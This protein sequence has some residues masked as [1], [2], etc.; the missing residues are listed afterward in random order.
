MNLNE[1][2]PSNYL[3]KNDLVNSR[4]LI[5]SKITRQEVWRKNG[6]QIA[7]VLHFDGNAKP[8]VLNKTNGIAIARIYGPD[9]STWIKKPIEVF[10]DPNVT[11]GRDRVGGIR[12]RAASV[13][14]AKISASPTTTAKQPHFVGAQS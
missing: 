4:V 1:M 13:V 14:P 3:T 6:K 5:M 12:V 2:F 7:I 11:L 9:T 8:M 10:H